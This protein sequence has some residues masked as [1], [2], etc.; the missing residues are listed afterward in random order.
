MPLYSIPVVGEPRISIMSIMPQQ[1]FDQL[2]VVSFAFQ[3]R[4]EYGGGP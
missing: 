1:R 4:F 2:F 3:V